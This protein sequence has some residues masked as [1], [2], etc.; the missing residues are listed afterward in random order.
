[1]RLF[2]CL[3]KYEQKQHHGVGI[4]IVDAGGDAIVQWNIVRYQ[5]KSSWS[6]IVILWKKKTSGL[7][8][9]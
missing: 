7:D 6:R 4:K 9:C 5:K 2:L 3:L 8:A 1:M